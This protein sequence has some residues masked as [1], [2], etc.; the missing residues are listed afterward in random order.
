MMSEGISD[1]SVDHAHRR[2][3]DTGSV[4]RLHRDAKLVLAESVERGPDGRCRERQSPHPGDDGEGTTWRLARDDGKPW[5]V[6]RRG[7]PHDRVNDGA[8][9]ALRQLVSGRIA[10][11]KPLAD[12][13]RPSTRACSFERLPTTIQR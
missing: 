8:R 13:V 4:P 6:G 3:R 7:V 10:F 9:G 5:S 2:V 1:H 11:A 12:R